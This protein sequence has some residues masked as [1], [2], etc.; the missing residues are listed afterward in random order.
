MFG[1]DRAADTPTTGS[2]RVAG[3]FAFASAHKKN[4]TQ[5]LSAFLGQCSEQRPPRFQVGTDEE[6]GWAWA[7]VGADVC[8]WT[9]DPALPFRYAM[10][11][12]PLGNFV[13]AS[14]IA[15][16]PRA[17]ANQPPIV[18]AVL[19][20]GGVY[21]AVDSVPTFHQSQFKLSPDERP[22][23]LSRAQS[24]NA[25]G[26]AAFILATSTG[27]LLTLFLKTQPTVQI[28]VGREWREATE[29][30]SS[31]GVI[32]K[33][34]SSVVGGGG[35]TTA[36]RRPCRQLRTVRRK[37]RFY[38]FVLSDSSLECFS[39]ADNQEWAACLWTK[40]WSELASQPMARPLDLCFAQQKNGA[41]TKA[42]ICYSSG[43][44]SSHGS[45][46]V[47]EPLGLLDDG[48]E[49]ASFEPVGSASR[50]SEPLELSA[51]RIAPG[52]AAADNPWGSILFSVDGSGKTGAV[53]YPV[54]DLQTGYVSMA[55]HQVDLEDRRLDAVRS[56]LGAILGVQLSEENGQDA[57]VTVVTNGGVIALENPKS[58]ELQQQAFVNE[59]APYGFANSPRSPRSPVKTSPAKQ[60]PTPI[61]V[62]TDRTPRREPMY[63]SSTTVA[64]GM[65][66]R[67][68]PTGVQPAARTTL[69]LDE[70]KD[71]T[72]RA[73]PSKCIETAFHY[74]RIGQ[75][76][77]VTQVLHELVFPDFD[78]EEYSDHVIGFV[79]NLLGNRDSA[80]SAGRVQQ[81]AMLVRF[82][83][84]DKKKRLQHF[85]SF[86]Q[87]SGLWTRLGEDNLTFRQKLCEGFEK[88]A[89]LD[90]LRLS[91]DKEPAVF[92]SA[93]RAC[94][95]HWG[96]IYG[97]ETSMVAAAYNDAVYLHACTPEILV[98]CVA[99]RAVESDSLET[100]GKV[101]KAI[102]LALEAALKVRQDMCESLGLA[103][104]Q[105]SRHLSTR[106]E[107]T[108]KGLG[109]DWWSSDVMLQAV[110]TLLQSVNRKLADT[111]SNA[112]KE[113]YAFYL[114]WLF[115]SHAYHF[116]RSNLWNVFLFFVSLDLFH[117]IL[118]KNKNQGS[119]RSRNFQPFPS[120]ALTTPPDFCTL[121]D[122]S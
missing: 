91:H 63:A 10:H 45:V 111:S 18:V 61:S 102:G 25:K 64:R 96:Q 80:D 101:C 68:G 48:S 69:P 95:Q 76:D 32:G 78:V 77:L 98:S 35:V 70:L 33:A 120:D 2:K 107:P 83:L 99:A 43:S 100:L 52:S 58:E 106:S 117:F 93:V 119:R 62:R 5:E 7:S 30:K 38:A 14:C 60:P 34:L 75:H 23:H 6:C 51:M 42:F 114:M 29:E 94:V 81:E 110:D 4:R 79:E 49:R 19:P 57:V 109:T 116:H 112:P 104:P 41:P 31:W 24:I 73:S 39:Q 115:V 28:A 44:A 36:T 1:R 56:D 55:I 20:R 54:E 66:G 92:A 59:S 88:L 65:F 47:V 40:Q 50:D 13:D 12:F 16:L 15:L 8:Y 21:V 9:L 71:A 103:K 97:A 84:E 118:S 122:I 74:F 53:S 89:L 121:F 87:E 113:L 105:P 85:A 72:G 26:E 82:A 46:V 86:L 17:N 37:G 90:S 22:T 11:S 27:R 3:G 67:S 108:P